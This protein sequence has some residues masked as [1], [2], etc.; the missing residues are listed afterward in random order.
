MKVTK[1]E[2]QRVVREVH[3]K[4]VKVIEWKGEIREEWR[5][6]EMYIDPHT[7]RNENAYTSNW[8]RRFYWSDVRD[9]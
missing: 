1:A 3:E 5:C 7:Y 6:S 2:M 4:Q 8:G 9:K